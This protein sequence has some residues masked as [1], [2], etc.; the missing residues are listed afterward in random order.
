M[1][2]LDL[3]LFR[4]SNWFSELEFLGSVKK[5]LMMITIAI[6]ITKTTIKDQTSTLVI[7]HLSKW[8]KL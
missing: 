5:L 6:N 7:I 3:Q 8:S 2:F 4:E 1:D